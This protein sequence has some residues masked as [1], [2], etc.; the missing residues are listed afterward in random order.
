[1]KTLY[2]DCFAGVSGDMILGACIDSGVPIEFL[3]Q[4]LQKLKL[5]GFEVT[6]ENIS[7]HNIGGTHVIV[8][9]DEQHHHRTLPVIEEIINNSSLSAYVKEHTK[10]IFHNL[11][12]AEAKIHNTTKDKIHFH[13]VGAL[14]AIVDITGAVICFEYLKVKQIFVSKIHVGSGFIKCAHGT[15]PL[16]APATMELLTDIPIFNTGIQNELT[17]PTGAAILKTM[18]TSFG[19]MPN[20][21]VESIGYG[22]GSRDLEIPNML[23]ILVGN[24]DNLHHA[25]YE[26][27]EITQIETNIDD[28]NPQLFEYLSD[29][30]FELGVLDITLTQTIMKKQRPAVIVT[31]LVDNS[32][33]DKVIEKLF[34]ETTTIGLRIQNIKRVKLKRESK[35][36]HTPFG[37]ISVK[38]SMLNEKTVQI[39]PEYEDCKKAAKKNNIPI[40][41][42]IE[43]AKNQA[44]SE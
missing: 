4:E 6:S 12:E 8:A 5:D 35:K 17:T 3:R 19:K 41:D 34:S 2:F 30:L 40:I 38:Y 25:Q 44:S 22:C 24:S 21:Q 32:L 28:M 42:I 36:V 14:D 23:R 16:P 15:M 26:T 7:K 31:I 9:T 29:E 39:K 11:A 10:K 43:S 1:M 33:K 20:M 18:A 13:E 27:D 37:D